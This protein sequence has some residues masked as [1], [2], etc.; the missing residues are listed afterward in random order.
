MQIGCQFLCFRK[1][2]YVYCILFLLT[3]FYFIYNKFL[4]S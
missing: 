3:L 4:P 1:I 2:S